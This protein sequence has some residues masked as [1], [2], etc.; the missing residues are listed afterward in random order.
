MKRISVFLIALMATI[1]LMA[2]DYMIVFRSGNGDSSSEAKLYEAIVLS[3]SDNIVTGA[4]MSKIYRAK[5]GYGIKGGT[6]S[7]KGTLSLKLDATYQPTAITVY[8]AAYGSDN[9]S[10]KGISVCGQTVNWGSNPNEIQPYTVQLTAPISAIT[11][12]ALAAKNCRFYVQKITFSCSDPQPTKAKV[13]APYILDMGSSALVDSTAAEEM[14]VIPIQVRGATD[15]VTVRLAHGAPFALGTS[16][17]APTGSDLDILFTSA[18]PGTFLDTLI[19]SAPASGGITT[20][21][22]AIKASAYF[23]SSG[24]TTI[25]STGMQISVHPG[26]YYAVAEGLSDSTLKSALSDIINCGVRYRYGSGARHT[27]DA[28]YQTDRDTATMRVLDMYSNVQRF[29]DAERPTASVL[30]FDIE[31][32]FPKSWWG[33]NVNAAYQDLYHLVPADYSANRSKSNHA[34]GFVA[35]TTFWN[36]SFATGYN[37]AYPVD[38]VFCPADEYKGDFARAY[39]YIATC[40]EDFAWV[41]EAGSEPSVAMNNDSYLEFEPWLQAVLLAWHRM[42]PVSE[43]ETTRA[44]TVNAIQGNRN[45]YIDYP[46]LVELIWGNRKGEAAHFGSMPCSFPEPISTGIEGHEHGQAGQSKAYKV[47]RHGEL[48]IVRD[49]KMYTIQGVLVNE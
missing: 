5:L 30:E 22:V 24:P 47:L 38:R 12:E 17:L 8:A 1:C 26:N 31:H 7:A 19:I 41:E 40:Y 2:E 44:I 33:G 46:D 35:D 39:F 11:I 13:T 49:G 36:G 27:W 21:R 37:S 42:D 45:P 20:R 9:T 32:M 25:D 15:S 16:H 34:P 18:Y 29:F 4:S 6:S 3:A 28:F 48:L 23:P 10:S 43:K 14:E